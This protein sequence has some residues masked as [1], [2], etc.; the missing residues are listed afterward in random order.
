MSV[1]GFAMARTAALLAIVSMSE[2]QSALGRDDGLARTP[3]MGSVIKHTCLFQRGCLPVG[4]LSSHTFEIST[5]AKNS[6]A[7]KIL[8]S[9]NMGVPVLPQEPICA[10][11]QSSHPPPTTRVAERWSTWYAF[12]GDI[13]ETKIVQM[14]DV[15]VSTGLRDAG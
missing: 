1:D 6:V 13:N 7:A 15:I 12:G 3:P 4:N 11:Q 9:C 8:A 14:A 2:L 10:D 5:T